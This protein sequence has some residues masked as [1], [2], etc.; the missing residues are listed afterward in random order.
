MFLIPVNCPN[1]VEDIKRIQATMLK[2]ANTG[3]IFIIIRT[4]NKKKNLVPKDNKKIIL[5]K[6]RI[7]IEGNQ[8]RIN[9]QEYNMDKEKRG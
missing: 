9:P 4:L 1:A 3:S 6:F 2:R 7:N 5:A 8:M